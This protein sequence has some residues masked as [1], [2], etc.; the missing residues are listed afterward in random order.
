MG[1]ASTDTLYLPPRHNGDWSPPALSGTAADHS[2]SCLPAF[3]WTCV[4]QAPTSRCNTDYW[5]RN[6]RPVSGLG[7]VLRQHCWGLLNEQKTNQKKISKMPLCIAKQV[8]CFL[9]FTL[10]EHKALK[11]KITPWLHTL[12]QQECISTQQRGVFY[13]AEIHEW[14][15]QQRNYV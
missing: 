10:L 8:L 2:H 3:P 9:V 4:H 11:R 12:N 6:K 15:C 14:H 5:M 1:F 7:P 13:I